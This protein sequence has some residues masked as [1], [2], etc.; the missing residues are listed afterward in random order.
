[1]DGWNDFVMLLGVPY[2]VHILVP[3]TGGLDRM[4]RAGIHQLVYLIDVLPRV[5]SEQSAGGA[6]CY[7]PLPI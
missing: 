4:P 3:S 2:L 5:E 1:M 7:E 6:I